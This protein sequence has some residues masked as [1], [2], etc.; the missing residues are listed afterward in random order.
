MFRRHGQ[1]HHRAHRRRAE[2]VAVRHGPAGG[3]SG[4][5][6]SGK[7]F[8]GGFTVSALFQAQRARSMGAIVYCV[9]VKEF[10]QTQV[11]GHRIINTKAPFYVIG[12]LVIYAT[13]ACDHCRHHRARVSCLGRLPVS[14]RNHRLGRTRERRDNNASLKKRSRDCLVCPLKDHQEVVHRDPRRRA[15][16]RV[17][18]R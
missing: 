14:Q 17:C 12:H 18:R 1:R 2:R 9:G 11:R 6:S 3:G 7:C 5:S 4:S 16:Q 10:N 13:P 15:V 8:G